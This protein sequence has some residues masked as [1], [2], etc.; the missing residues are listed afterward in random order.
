MFPFYYFS[1]GDNG[2]Q[3]TVYSLYLDTNRFVVKK[4]MNV[5]HEVHFKKR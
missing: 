1:L 3:T 2:I 4:N 5:L